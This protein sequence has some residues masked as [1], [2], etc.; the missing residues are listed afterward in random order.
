MTTN[1]KSE[2]DLVKFGKMTKHEKAVAL[3]GKPGWEID[4]LGEIDDNDHYIALDK[5]SLLFYA[6]VGHI[7]DNMGQLLTYRNLIHI[8]KWDDKSEEWA[9][10]LRI[11]KLKLK[12]VER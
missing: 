4:R 1:N 12:G 3:L 5:E 8:H 9:P 7:A 11:P 10:M 6:F 2:N